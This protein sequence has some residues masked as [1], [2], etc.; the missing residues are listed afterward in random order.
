Y[1]DACTWIF[2]G[3]LTAAQRLREIW[4]KKLGYY[5]PIY[6]TEPL[7]NAMHAL[8]DSF[9]RAHVRRVKKDDIWV[10][11]GVFIYDDENKKPSG[12]YP[13]HEALDKSWK[14]TEVGL[15]AITACRELIRIMIRTS[16]VANSAQVR[17]VWQSLWDTFTGMFLS[18]G[19]TD[20]AAV[21]K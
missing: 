8:Q 2:T 11:T 10:I 1:E 4:V 15:E 3:G 17:T 13:G 6:V 12:D 20:A 9:S 7:G 16:L 14:E 19:I 21:A 5:N 18:C